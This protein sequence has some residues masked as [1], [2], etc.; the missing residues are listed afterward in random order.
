MTETR[1][2]K[3]IAADKLDE[4]IERLE[5]AEGPSIELDGM[6]WAAANGYEFVMWDGAGCVYRDPNAPNWNR[7]IQ[8]ADATTVRPYSASLDA[9]VALAERVLP[10]WYWRCGRTVLFPNGWAYVSRLHADHCTERDEAACSD[11]KAA[12]VAI[13]LCLATLK[14]ARVHMHPRDREEQNDG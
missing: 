1:T 10:G 11:G 9:A 2:P 4:L 3:Q 7:G 14:A 12:N 13:A 5:K 6:I 8:H